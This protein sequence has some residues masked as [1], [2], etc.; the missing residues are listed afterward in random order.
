M[1]GHALE[2]SLYSRKGRGLGNKDNNIASPEMAEAR[3]PRYKTSLSLWPRE[4]WLIVGVLKE[5]GKRAGG[6]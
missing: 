3:V 5:I 4:Q 6:S 2:G 1:A